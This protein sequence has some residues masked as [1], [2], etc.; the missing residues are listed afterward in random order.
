[1]LHNA[2]KKRVMTI[3][4]SYTV[5]SCLAL[6]MGMFDYYQ[7]NEKLQCPVCKIELSEW[8]G[9]DANCALLLWKQGQSFP[10]STLQDEEIEMPEEIRRTWRLPEKFRIYS[11][12]CEKHCV[13]VEG[14]TQD[15]VWTDSRISLVEEVGKM[16][17]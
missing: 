9:K 4:S 11:Y 14:K 12:D 15:G 10:E 6:V 5:V 17:Y 2:L 8:Q 7:L 1:M 16:R 13:W 3:Q